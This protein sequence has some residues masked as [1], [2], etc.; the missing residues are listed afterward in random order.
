MRVK[1]WMVLS[2]ASTVLIVLSLL[3]L[4]GKRY[5][6]QLYS[7]FVE[8]SPT[9]YVLIGLAI[10]SGIAGFLV[11][12]SQLVNSIA[13]GLV[14]KQREKPAELIYR[15]RILERGPDV[16][17]LGGGTGLSVLLRGLKQ[18]TS[19]ISA[20]VTVMDDGGS[21]GRLRSELDVLPP[22]DIRNCV[23]ALAEDEQRVSSLFQYRFQ[24]AA[25]LTGH[26][27]GNLL[28]LVWSRPPV[29]SIARLKK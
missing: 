16:V 25:E 9:Y 5:V 7:F 28:W 14:P 29:A 10:A 15:T 24:G 27:L 13:Q 22:G 19:N 1:R 6:G 12:V 18:V 4:V 17:A 2:L 21:S 3:V 8:L 11:G 26:S 23:L 20:V